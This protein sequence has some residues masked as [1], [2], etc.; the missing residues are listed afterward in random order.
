M[1]ASPFAAVVLALAAA[2]AFAAVKVPDPP[3]PDG[4]AIAALVDQYL[5]ASVGAT[6]GGGWLD[7][8]PAC[9]VGAA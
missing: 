3:G 9:A 2:P 1:R 4:A 6:T 5:E 7:A 8:A